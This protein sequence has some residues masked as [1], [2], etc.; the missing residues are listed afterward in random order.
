MHDGDASA[1]RGG[2]ALDAEGG[3]GDVEEVPLFVCPAP[4]TLRVAW[5]SAFPSGA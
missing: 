3:S 4:A 5:G 2:V 1:E